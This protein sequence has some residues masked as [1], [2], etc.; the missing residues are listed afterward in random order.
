[1]ISLKQFIKTYLWFI[2]RPILD[3]YRKKKKYNFIKKDILRLQSI[4]ES[5]NNNQPYIYY[6]GI[7]A[8]SN[9]GDMGHYY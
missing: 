2:Y 5:L 3:R 7:T 6:L 1:M 4:K 8:H 9:L